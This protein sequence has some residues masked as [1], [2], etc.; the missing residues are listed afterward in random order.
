M[1]HEHRSSGLTVSAFCR[2]RAVPASSLYAWKRR[3]ES[4]SASQPTPASFVAVRAIKDEDGGGGPAE[5]SA[6]SLVEL[7]LGRDRRLVIRRGFDRRLLLE[8][9]RVL[10]GEPC[11]RES[12][13]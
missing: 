4:E 3:L 6:S 9:I 10:E 2:K 1:V 11:A 8:V 5:P 12:L 13:S 7:W